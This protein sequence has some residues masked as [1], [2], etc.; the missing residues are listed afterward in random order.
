MVAGGTD[1]IKPLVTH[2][3]DRAFRAAPFL[4]RGG[5]EGAPD[6][7]PI[8]YVVHESSRPEARESK[9]NGTIAARIGSDPDRKGDRNG[10]A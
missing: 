9:P 10:R 6:P 1:L 3:V 4:K 5:A 7:R 8:R 2:A